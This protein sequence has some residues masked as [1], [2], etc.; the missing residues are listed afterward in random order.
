MKADYQILIVDDDESI[1]RMLSAVLAREGFQTVTAEDGEAGLALFRSHSPDIVLM[2]IRM[3]GLSGIEAMSAM[4]ELRPGAAVI[5]MTAYAD[6]ETAVQAI[7]N[8]VFDFVIKPFDLAEIGLLINRAYEMREM[9]RE[10]G[11]LQ[12]ELS[13]NF[14]FDRIITGDPAMQALCES[15]ARIAASNATVVI[16]GESGVG[17]EL[18]A[19]SLHYNSPRAQR[20]FVKVNCGAI[21]EGLLESEFFGHEKGA[22][23]G[24]VSRRTGRFE[25]ADGG[26]LFLDEIGELPLSLQVK[27]LRV[28]QDREFE[29]VGGEKT[30]RVD[31]RLVAATNR[32]LEEMVAAGTF[33]S[34]LY[35]RLN[36]VSLSV[37]PLRQRPADIPL[38]ATH[39][40]RK[41]TAEHKREIDGFDDHALAIM[42]RYGWPGN[43]RELSNAVERAVVMSSGRSIFSEDLPLSIVQ[44]SR[45]L[46]A[47]MAAAPK[48]LKEQVLG[49]ETRVIVQALERN[50][51]NRSRTASELGISRRALLYKLH[52][53]NLDLGECAESVADCE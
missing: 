7:K 34:D 33:R 4:L 29:R 52:E 14:R 38:L 25:H 30:L 26:T 18:L 20:A 48:S 50:K 8:G 9:R 2:D 32:N 19:A 21:P 12:H 16:C 27:L 13:E 31:V 36:V 53:F 11:I 22:F 15:V 17:K 41:Y 35:Y 23:T 5:L 46:P 10:I 3:P 37:P 6:L 40:L 44:A 1:R 51:G 42:Q 24:A 47:D 45:P 28:L 43:V 49:F 39:F